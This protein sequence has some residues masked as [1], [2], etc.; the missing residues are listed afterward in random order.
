MKNKL[1]FASVFTVLL[2]NNIRKLMV[3]FDILT[4]LLTVFL[5]IIILFTFI[6]KNKFIE[7]VEK[8]LFFAIIILIFFTVFNSEDL[9]FFFGD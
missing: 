3:E 2:I 4:L 8:I 7:V 5:G 1:I 6:K 9:A